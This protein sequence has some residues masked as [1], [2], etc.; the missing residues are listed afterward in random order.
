MY[1]RAAGV[2]LSELGI[3]TS[4]SVVIEIPLIFYSKRILNR[5]GL[6]KMLWLL[7]LTNMLRMVVLGFSLSFWWFFAAGIIRG[8]FV[9]SFIPFFIELI[10]Q[11]TD[12]QLVTSGIAIYSAVS[13][14]L[15]SFIFTMVGSA[16]TALYSYQMMYFS[17]S[18]IIFI[19]VLL[20]KKMNTL[21]GQTSPQ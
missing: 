16:V 8:V 7:T 9:G 5:L 1:T 12:D 10:S 2:S 11:M 3:I 17:L 6:K 21:I 18:A 4:V 13:T 20:L 15:G 14:G 19:N